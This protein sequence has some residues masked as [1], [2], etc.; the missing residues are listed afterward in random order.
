MTNMGDTPLT[1]PADCAAAL[2]RVLQ[3][4]DNVLPVSMPENADRFA[5]AATYLQQV[6]ELLD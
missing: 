2:D 5:L 1:S 6:I 3:C 4:L